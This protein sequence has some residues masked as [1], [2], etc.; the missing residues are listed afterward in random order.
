MALDPE[1]RLLRFRVVV[2][3]LLALEFT[4]TLGFLVEF[5]HYSLGVVVPSACLLI[6][7]FLTGV[8]YV[9]GRTN[10]RRVGNLEKTVYPVIQCYGSECWH[11]NQA[12]VLN[13]EG[14]ALLL[15]ALQE[16]SPLGVVYA[17]TADGEGYSLV[18]TCTENPE[19]YPLPY[20][21]ALGTNDSFRAQLR[22]GLPDPRYENYRQ[23][24]NESGKGEHN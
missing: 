13:E 8:L 20:L 4:L 9:R 11:D 21:D 24:G 1:K 7:G 5:H 23:A 6:G 15:N 3:I 18:I 14:R 10:L 17:M 19:K 2:I 12:I 22:E 16:N